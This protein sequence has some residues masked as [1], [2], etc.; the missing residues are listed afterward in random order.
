VAGLSDPWFRSHFNPSQ[1]IGIKTIPGVLAGA[2]GSGLWNLGLGFVFPACPTLARPNSYGSGSAG[3]LD[4]FLKIIEIG[5]A[6]K[7]KNQW[8]LC[9]HVSTLFSSTY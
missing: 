9:G 6:H 7:Y 4:A 2:P 1:P 5:P 3:I 8:Y